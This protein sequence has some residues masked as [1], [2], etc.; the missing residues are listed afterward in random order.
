MRVLVT[1]AF[2]TLGRAGVRELLACGH[3]VRCLDVPTRANRRAA[4]RLGARVEVVWGDVCDAACVR[5]AVAGQ[6]AVLHDAAILAP[7]SEHDPERSWAVNVEGT[8]GLVAVLAAA[9]PDA[10]LVYPS[11]VTVFGADPARRKPVRAEDP[12]VATDHYTRQKLAC[13]EIVRTSTLAWVVLRVGVCVD[14]TTKRGDLDALRLLFEVSPDNRL[15]YVHP[16]DVARAQVAALGCPEAW[17]R[18]LLVGGG[19]S[20]QVRHHAL[21]DALFTALGVAPP[22]RAAFGDRPFYTEWMDTADSQRLLTYQRRSFDDFRREMAESMRFVRRALVPVRALVRRWLLA[23]SRLHLLVALVLLLAASA[24]HALDDINLETNIADLLATPPHTAGDELVERR[25]AVL[26]EFGYGPDTGVVLGAKFTHRDV[27]ATD[28]TLDVEAL[29]GFA[30]DVDLD[31]TLASPRLAGGRLLV[32]VNAGY[33][34]DPSRD[35]FGLG[36][37]DVGPDTLS[38]HLYERAQA[39][40]AAAWRPLPRLALGVATGVRHVN[41]GRGDRSG[42]TP[43]TVVAFPGLP[44]VDGGFLVPLEASL[45]WN[46][47]DGIVRPTRGW[48]AIAKVSHVNPALGSDARFTR[49]VTDLGYLFPFHDGAQVLGLRANAGY[50]AGNPRHE[51]FWALEELGGDDTLEGYFPR[52]FLGSARVLVN[53]ELRARLWTFPFF[54]L[55]QV[56]VDGALFGGAGRVFVDLDDLGRRYAP[57][58][59]HRIRVS[60]GPGLRIALSQAL[61]ARVD[62]GF[63]NEETGIVYLAFDHTF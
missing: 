39:F 13:E 38:T 31:A 1:G 45:V 36:N 42:T 8:R 12:V 33:R 46:T 26:P 21:V 63:S 34:N 17:G 16:E 37:N 61:V 24:A 6:E 62:V 9:A 19:A 14:P 4:S 44:G 56:S 58:D 18:V 57:A 3:Q 25:W 54:D 41:I 59:T 32:L 29:Y 35:F 15:E 48:R 47:R 53:A 28:T 11:S 50:L 30:G 49:W 23:R 55:W 51:P 20:C 60:G 40:A 43:L 22:P 5:A 2:G 27:A 10:V 7:A 52:R